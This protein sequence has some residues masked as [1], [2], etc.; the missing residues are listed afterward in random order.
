MVTTVTPV[1][2]SASIILSFSNLFRYRCAFA[3]V[4]L[5]ALAINLIEAASCP[6]LVFVTKSP[7]LTVRSFQD[8]S[9]SSQ[10][11]ASRSVKVSVRK[12]ALSKSRRD[13]FM[14]PLMSFVLWDL[15]RV[16]PYSLL[17]AGRWHQSIDRVR[18][19]RYGSSPVFW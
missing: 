19:P 14:V 10:I 2:V 16:A 4:Q 9:I 5:H 17:A 7:A 13:I 1:S 8:A 18:I 15:R 6:R 11:Q 3:G 12:A